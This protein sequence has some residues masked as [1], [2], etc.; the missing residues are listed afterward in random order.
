M[1]ILFLTASFFKQGAV[2]K[3]AVELAE[4]FAKDNEVHV[5]TTWQKHD[6]DGVTFHK[7]PIPRWPYYMLI[8]LNAVKNTVFA[9]KLD[10]EHKFDIIHSQGAESLYQ[11]ILKA[12]SCH[13]AAV[14]QFKRERGFG[15]RVLKTFEPASNIV[16]QIE[17]YNLTHRN[18]K[19]L[20]ALSKGNLREVQ[21]YYGVPDEYIRLIPNGVNIE[22]F[23]P[24]NRKL[25]RTDVRRMHGIDEND[26]VLLFVGWEFKRKGLRHVIE[27]LPHLPKDVK[28]VAVG[29][30]KRQPYER[31]AAELGVSDR[32]VF[33]G[34]SSEARKYYASADLFVF[35]TAYEGFSM[36]TLEAAASGLP[37]LA[38]LVNGTEDL[39]REG[40]NGFFIEREGKDIAEKVRHVL[41][42]DLLGR[43]SAKARKS[44]LPHS[45]DSIAAKTMQLY[46]E[47]LE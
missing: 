5:L 32:V 17:K 26:I 10:K 20:I 33:T 31:R 45:W 23:T 15:Y 1:K 8:G 16:L 35:P 43:M 41:D 44:A 36:A 21:H 38:T 9:R 24:E 39:I 18:F 6:I 4:R 14:E 46:E 28:L 11:N 40:E 34:H 30:D 47:V 29:G 25:Y 19:K 22:E 2:A 13:K 27:A 3:Y 7:I 42:D 12:P 37:V